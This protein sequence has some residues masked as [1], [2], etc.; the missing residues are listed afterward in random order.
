MTYTPNTDPVQV[1]RNAA[2][3]LETNGWIQGDFFVRTGMNHEPT[4]ACALGAIQIAVV[5]FALDVF[6][7]FNPGAPEFDTTVRAAG[8]VVN[9][10]RQ[11]HNTAR[12]STSSQTTAL[13]RWNDRN[14][15]TAAEVVT[16][17]RE[18]ADRHDR[19]AS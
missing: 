11:L 3:Y 5:G 12:L 8:L 7:L 1:L 15:R 9:H 17:M 13:V 19:E 18:A 4:A 10:L 6:S 14:G 2:D 16:A